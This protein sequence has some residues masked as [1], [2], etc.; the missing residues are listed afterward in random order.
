MLRKYFFFCVNSAIEDTT[1]MAKKLTRNE[2]SN[3]RLCIDHAAWFPM[4][5]VKK[6]IQKGQVSFLGQLNSVID[7]PA[8]PSESSEAAGIHNQ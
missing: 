2:V 3:L 5:A 1:A 6:K 7:I 8:R 4:E